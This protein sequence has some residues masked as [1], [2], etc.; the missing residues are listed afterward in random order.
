MNGLWYDESAS[1]GGNQS[2]GNQSRERKRPV[3]HG[4]RSG[5]RESPGQH[6]DQSRE[7]QRPVWP[8]KQE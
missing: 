5:E 6:G 4:N 2:Q 7:R 3:W 1:L 8:M